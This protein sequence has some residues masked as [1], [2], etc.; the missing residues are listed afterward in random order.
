MKVKLSISCVKYSLNGYTCDA[1][2]Q[3]HGIEAIDHLE[4]NFLEYL[5][6]LHDMNL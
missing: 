1:L 5:T 6:I 2:P 4:F 3:Y